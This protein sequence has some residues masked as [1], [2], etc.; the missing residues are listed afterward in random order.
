[1]FLPADAHL[2]WTV[3]MR[4]RLR[5]KF[6][7]ACSAAGRAL[8]A[9]GAWEKTI[10]LYG[11]A[12]EADDLAEEFYQGL[13]RCYHQSGRDAEAAAVFGRL[14]QRLSVTLGLAPSPASAALF[15]QIRSNVS[16]H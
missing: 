7:L 10:A 3:S 4:E 14:R 13:M 2:P 16:N 1:M 5:R 8:E 12:L 11:R 6:V 9:S 15:G